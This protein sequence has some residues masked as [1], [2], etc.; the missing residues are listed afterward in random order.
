M[1]F[2]KGLVSTFENKQYIYSNKELLNI[3]INKKIDI[4]TI[5]DIIVKKIYK[6]TK[7]ILQLIINGSTINLLCINN[8]NMRVYQENIK[9]FV[10]QL[11]DL[12][13][14]VDIIKHI[15]FFFWGDYTLNN[16]GK[17]R[18]TIKYLYEKHNKELQIINNYLNSQQLQKQLIE[19][20]MFSSDRLTSSISGIVIENKQKYHIISKEKVI[21]NLIKEK[22]DN[23]KLC[24][25]KLI[26]NNKKRNI[27]FKA[28][29][30]CKRK[31]VS[32]CF[33]NIIDYF[34]KYIVEDN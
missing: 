28:S 11:L 20:I 17:K 24:V 16:T 8:N 34:E 6:D 23:Q 14:K 2:P 9:K 1:K 7:P 10:N 32:I 18:Y 3:I 4:S 27:N 26:I 22:I 29:D 12:S 21:N 13:I 5:D 15:L 25:S 33:Y 30:E 19:L 31:F